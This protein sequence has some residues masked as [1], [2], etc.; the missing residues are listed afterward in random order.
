MD[1]V[2]DITDADGNPTG[3]TVTR[4][5]AHRKGIRHRTSHLWLYRYRDG[6][7]QLL[8]QKRSQDK[9]S[10]PGCYDI[11]SA[12]HI[13]AGDGF[14]ESALRELK[15]ELGIEASEDMLAVIGQSVFEFEQ[16]VHG[17]H[18]HDVQ[19]SRVFLMPYE[20][21][22]EE[23]EFQKSEIEEVRWMDF[24]DVL[25]MIRTGRP[26]SCVLPEEMEMI[27]RVLPESGKP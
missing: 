11:S 6:K 8:L 25:E 22:A 1:E 17:K 23:I 19:V 12:G 15:E 27:R 3:R 10:C 13:P 4:S 9:E 26:D 18:F 5:E 7:L 14:A 20:K 21:N 2:L 24:E 16:D